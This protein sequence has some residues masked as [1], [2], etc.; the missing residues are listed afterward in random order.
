MS[1]LSLAVICGRRNSMARLTNCHLHRHVV[2]PLAPSDTTD[3]LTSRAYNGAK[4]RPGR[5]RPGYHLACRN[6]K[7]RKTGFNEAGAILV[8]ILAAVILLQ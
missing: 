2:I 8:L 4:M 6:R 5:S 3:I 1:V 7:L